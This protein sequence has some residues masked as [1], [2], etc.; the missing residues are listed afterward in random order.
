[1]EYPARVLRVYAKEIKE[2]TSSIRKLIKQMEEALFSYNAYGIAANQLNFSKRIIVVRKN[3]KGEKENPDEREALV[4]INP[5]IEYFS[6]EMSIEEEGCLSLPN[7]F[8]PILRSI[9]ISLKA[10]NIEGEEL[11]YE[12]SHLHARIIQHEVDH[13]DG[14]LI[15]DRYAAYKT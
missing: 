1:V 5:K 4:F 8:L 11:N 2:V 10:N 6:E 7:L 15:I 13:L 14:I 9:R 3:L 12:F